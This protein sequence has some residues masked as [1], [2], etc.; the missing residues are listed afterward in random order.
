MGTSKRCM[1]AQ[2]GR[3]TKRKLILM[4]MRRL[5]DE[6]ILFYFDLIQLTKRTYKPVCETGVVFR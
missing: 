1:K 2:R 5:R 6:S 3:R 4:V